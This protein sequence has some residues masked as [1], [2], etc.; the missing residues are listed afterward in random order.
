MAN[1]AA[2]SGFEKKR[3]VMKSFHINQN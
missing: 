2:M 1:N 3:L